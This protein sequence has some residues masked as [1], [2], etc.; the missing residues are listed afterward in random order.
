MSEI[1]NSLDWFNMLE[2][3]KGTVIKFEDKTIEIIQSLGQRENI[4]IK[5][6]CQ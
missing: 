2:V 4:E 5:I 1:R 3:R 6:E